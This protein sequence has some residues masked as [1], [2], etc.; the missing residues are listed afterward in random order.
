MLTI[1]IK[2]H[3]QCAPRRIYEVFNLAVLHGNVSVQYKINNKYI[4]VTYDETQ[5]AMIT[6]QPYLVCL[7]ANGQFSKIDAPF[8]ALKNPPSSTAALYAKNDQ[9]IGVYVPISI[10]YTTCISTHYNHIKPLDFHF[11][12]NHAR[13]SHNNDLF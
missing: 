8:Q 9:E 4:G 3:T 7:H 13:I 10:S 2:L 6:Q 5:A 12:P 1:C 11:D